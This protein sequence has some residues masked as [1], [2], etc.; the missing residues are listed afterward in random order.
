MQEYK[1]GSP[2]LRHSLLLA[3]NM[4]AAP[5]GSLFPM[6]VIRT[7]IFRDQV[8]SHTC[9]QQLF[10]PPIYRTH[11]NSKHSMSAPIDAGLN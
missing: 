7:F 4:L 11:A 2:A 6:D 3:T 10:L 8:L 1:T 5:A 9:S